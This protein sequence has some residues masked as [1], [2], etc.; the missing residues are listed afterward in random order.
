MA[1]ACVAWSSNSFECGV[2]ELAERKGGGGEQEGYWSGQ[3]SESGAPR[4]A[5]DVALV[6]FLQ[7]TAKHVQLFI[8][9]PEAEFL[10]GA[11]QTL[12]GNF[13]LWRIAYQS[14]SQVH[15]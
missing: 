2:G 11:S 5:V 10:V 1:G 7:S 8:H 4:G 15:F 3:S 14:S 13:H 9:N 6:P 12:A